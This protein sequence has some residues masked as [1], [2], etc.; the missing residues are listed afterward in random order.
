MARQEISR[1]ITTAHCCAG[2]HY[3][4]RTPPS[5]RGGGGGWPLLLF[6]HGAGERGPADGSRLRRAG[7][8][9][10]LKV[11][12]CGPHGLGLPNTRQ[13]LICVPQCHP[14]PLTWAD[15]LPSLKAVVD[16]LC[17]EY[18]VDIGRIYLTGLSMGGMGHII[19][20]LQFSG[21]R[22]ANYSVVAAAIMRSQ[23]RFSMYE[24]SSWVLAG[25][26]RFVGISPGR[27]NSSLYS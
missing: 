7:V 10:P 27:D 12:E 1:P 13:F 4:L 9:G 24:D 8:H 22:L 18:P 16:R 14:A 11:C 23:V 3:L 19:E 25:S 17:A 15:F 5:P 6:L 2:L 20:G 21:A 26:T